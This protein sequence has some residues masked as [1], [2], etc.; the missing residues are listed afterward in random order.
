MR[1]VMCRFT[2]IVALVFFLSA[3]CLAQGN[4]HINESATRLQLLDQSTEV[5]LAIENSGR[6]AVPARVSLELVDPQGRVQSRASKEVSVAPGLTKLN[7][8]MPP[9][10][11]QK[12]KTDRENL[13]WYRL[14]YSVS[15][16]PTSEAARELIQG[17]LSVSEAAPKMFE[18]YV[19]SPG[20][21]KGGSRA[22]IRVR[23]VHPVTQHPIEGVA[24]Q[25]S[26]DLDTADDKPLLT[27]EA[28]T[29]RQGFA[30]LHASIPPGIDSDQIDVN[31]TG[32]LGNVS[33]EASG[34]LNVNR[35]SSIML[36]TDKGMYQPGQPLHLRLMAFDADGKAITNQA[37]TLEIR[38]PDETLVF[39]ASPQ[40]S[41]FGVASTDWQIPDNLRLGDYQIQAILGE[42][43]ARSPNTYARVKISRYDLPT[44]SVSVKSDHPTYL[45]GQN[46]EIEVRADYLF[47]EP[48]RK[49][50]VRVV[51]ESER[52]WNFNEQKWEIKEAASYE[53]DTDEQ[54]RYVAHVDLSSEQEDLSGNDYERFQD[55]SFAAYYTDPSTGKTEQRRFDVRITKE[56]IHVYVIAANKSHMEGLPLEFYL[57]TD[58][59]NGTPAACEVEIQWGAADEQG[60]PIPT[61]GPQ[62]VRRV[63]TNRYGVAKVTGLN[64]PAQAA[65]GGV[66]LNF[67]A[68]DHKGLVGNHAESNWEADRP[69]VRVETNKTLY[70]P[71]EP[72]D[73]ELSASH[74]DMILAVEV[75][76]EAQVLASRLVHVRHGHASLT[77]STSEKFQ[78]EITILAYALGTPADDSYNDNVGDHTVY[79]PKNYELKVDIHPSK[80]TY[81]P[82]EEA[83]ATI[84]VT[85]PDG[86]EKESALGL[87][88]VDKAVEER[89]RTDSEF[90]G[91]SG[92]L[93]FPRNWNNDAELNGVR[94]GDLDKLDLAK[95]LPDG[96]E[97]AAEAM[98]QNSGAYADIFNSGTG[99]KDLRKLF[100]PGIDPVIK[101]FH[102]VL[103]MRYQKTGEYPKTDAALKDE[104]ISSGILLDDLRDP[105]GVP[106]RFRFSVKNE[107]DVLELISAGPDKRFDTEDDF[108]AMKLVWPYFKP[109]A[110]A[111]QKAV[112]EFHERTGGYI[113]DEETLRAELARSGIDL[114][115]LKDPW[116]HTYRLEFGVRQTKFTVTVMSAGPDGRFDTKLA[117][118]QD[119]FALG[120][121]AIDYFVDT[122]AKIDVALN[123]SFKDTHLF[124]ENVEQFTAILESAGISWTS[125]R[126]PWGNPYYATFRQDALYADRVGVETYESH[127]GK[128]E[129]RVEVLPVTRQMNFL[130]IQSVG[131]DS[132]KNTSDDFFVA[133]FS[134]ASFERSGEGQGQIPAANAVI[135]SGTNGAISGSVTDQSGGAIS[136]AEITA[137]DLVSGYSYTATADEQGNYVLRN[138]PAGEYEVRFKSVGFRESVITGVPVRSSNVTNLNMSLQ[139]GTQSQTVTVTESV[140][141]VETTNATL[142]AVVAGTKMNAL[143]MPAMTPRL[144]QYFPETLLW[145]PELVTDAG[146]RAHLKF[147][148]ADNITTWKISGI[149]S[150]ESGEIGTVEKEIRAFQPFF[151]EHDPPKFLTVGDEIDLPVVMRNYLNHTIHMTEELK[152]EAWFA[153][154]SPTSVNSTVAPLDNK[155]EVFKFQATAP[156]K[157][158]K[159]RIIANGAEVGDAIERTVT[160]R[161]NGEEYVDTISQVFGDSTGVDVRIPDNTISGSFEGTLK[162]YPNLNAHVL[163]S[164][165]AI[166]GRPYGCAEQTISSAYPSLLLLEYAKDAHG[167]SP[168]MIARAKRYVQLGYGRLLS[169]QAPDGGITYWGRGDSDIALTAYAMKFLSEAR[170][171]ADVDDSIAQADLNWLLRQE[172][173]DGR[174]IAPTW[175]GPE[176]F[177]RTAILTGYI[178]RVIASTT[179]HSG[180]PAEDARLAKAASAAVARALG[181]LE[182][183][184]SSYDEPYLIASYVLASLAARDKSRV[185]ENLARLRQ[186]EHREGDFSYWSLESN[187]PFYGWGTAGRIETT[188]LVLQA[189]QKA[190]ENK[191]SQDPSTSRGLLFLLHNQDR[192]GIWYSS[193]ATINVLD[194]LCSLTSQTQPIGL[195]KSSSASLLVDGR[196]VIS[197]DMPGP[198][199]L[200]APVTIDISKFVSPG[201]HH[202]QISRDAGFPR[203]SLQV[204][205][206]YYLPWVHTAKEENVH[207]EDKSSDALRLRVQYEKQSAKAGE[208]IRCN[209]EAER[210]GFR[211]YGMMLAEIGLP[212]GAEVDRSSIE[213]A[214]K[215]SGWDINQYEVLPDRL[216]VYLWPHAGGT[217]F[218]FTFKPRF[219]MKALTPPSTLY[220]YYNP[221]AQAVVEPTLFSVN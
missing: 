144:R 19:A 60:R 160:V 148:L 201:A 124:P 119:D 43:G 51:Q 122:L 86:D 83:S 145:Q 199:V 170:E 40:T 12:E 81:R 155:N 176:D 173:K 62:L 121:A 147:P 110:E 56:P 149:A 205:S 2:G 74:Q 114:G 48:V 129:R 105:W 137:V 143:P 91:Y 64:I 172:Q 116:G 68:R 202:L 213:T 163:E 30:T 93:R 136:R 206:D 196:K 189:F 161:P 47:G 84:H 126:D 158:G 127:I 10:I 94:K 53:G 58:Y 6:E 82:G 142:G 69:G 214:M 50:H 102:D 7:L 111:I 153:N 77:F 54:G 169:Y 150:T 65:A 211:G 13:L 78:N 181:Y 71:N 45:P 185:A 135:L 177:H 4:L 31:V 28:K 178:S 39:R 92:F 95:P 59:A 140:P 146:G 14:R 11:A 179:I 98:L 100:A 70:A 67:R 52:N 220:D 190:S 180:D 96:F 204:I 165:E 162:I 117:P 215:E 197:F 32:K 123:K 88:V 76:H 125:L 120:T 167:V 139:V 79:F 200:T 134:R 49:G 17:V 194:T 85:G 63:R 35:F 207:H 16:T 101:P 66:Y 27:P 186:L 3:A 34:E 212:P 128:A 171:F 55:L 131:E 151:V 37:A 23:A 159:Q 5:G 80:L 107:M 115:S 97:V 57:S 175:G 21:V 25:A 26:L 216:V 89:I 15:G 90:V 166:L 154:L 218:S 73:V 187:T 18:L 188:A 36:T 106:Y 38:D 217:K 118:S 210:I 24:V 192:Y 44:F 203:A 42:S 33:A 41:R 191:S 20:M 9:A 109:N 183:Q 193:Q 61:V 219:G 112:N 108:P 133:T 164:I 46:A 141:Q 113:R 99:D 22:T 174:W 209:I 198:T 132:V 72:I 152:S 138:L 104:L 195:S 168:E 182:K 87:V 157:N 208:N 184:T 8:T 1:Y 75:M 156:I 130:Y 29:D 221:E 103:M